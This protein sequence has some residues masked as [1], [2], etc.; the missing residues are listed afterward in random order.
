M[1]IA[2]L[3][4]YLLL[5]G[6]ASTSPV[7]THKHYQGDDAACITITATNFVNPIS[8]IKDKEA[9]VWLR[10]IDGLPTADEGRVCVSPGIHRLTAAGFNMREN[11]SVRF[12]FDI[13]P[14]STYHLRAYRAGA[15]FH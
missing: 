4:L 9:H 5:A 2:I 14:K 1:K 12:D 10:E 7:P 11:S 3:F 15:L 6:C 8:F 13:Q